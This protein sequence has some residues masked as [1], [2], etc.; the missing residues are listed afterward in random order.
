MYQQPQPHQIFHINQQQ[1]QQ[2]QQ[3][4]HNGNSNGGP[5][6]HNYCNVAPLLGDVVKQSGNEYLEILNSHQNQP[7]ADTDP[8]CQPNGD[9]YYENTAAVLSRLKDEGKSSSLGDYIV[10]EPKAFQVGSAKTE[11]PLIPFEPLKYVGGKN[12]EI[13][14]PPK[15]ETIDPISQK[16]RE[17]QDALDTD[18]TSYAGL[19][20]NGF[21]VGVVNGRDDDKTRNMFNLCDLGQAFQLD[22]EIDFQSLLDT[23]RSTSM[24]ILS[25]TG[26]LNDLPPPPPPEPDSPKNSGAGAL[27]IPRTSKNPGD[28]NPHPVTMRRSSSVPS[29]PGTDRGSTSSSDSGFS[30]GSPNQNTSN[31]LSLLFGS[32]H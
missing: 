14:V 11:M 8:A 7:P 13:S 31:S 18:E 25:A 26:W 29:K 30:P 32:K 1:Q 12:G 16:L 21:N 23:N 28:P 5:Q 27:T 3:Q 17:F 6:Y 2:Q 20:G 15:Y 10:M 9:H 24:E 19:V 4:Q 22:G